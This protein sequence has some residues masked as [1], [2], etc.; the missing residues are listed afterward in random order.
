MKKK[1][2]GVD[3]SDSFM[4]LEKAVEIVRKSVKQKYGIDPYEVMERK[5]QEKGEQASDLERGN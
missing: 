5:A 3:F 1:I 4:S 2:A